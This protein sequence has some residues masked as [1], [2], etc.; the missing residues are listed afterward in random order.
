MCILASAT[1]QQVFLGRITR[2]GVR[3]IPV[4]HGICTFDYIWTGQGALGCGGGWARP[5]G[6]SA[7]WAI[8]ACAIVALLPLCIF[9][10]RVSKVQSWEPGGGRFGVGT[11]PLLATVPGLWSESHVP[12]RE[13]W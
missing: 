2:R 10:S 13:L 7:M 12:V 1:V 9:R 4:T 5:R 8:A 6:G 3:K 11:N